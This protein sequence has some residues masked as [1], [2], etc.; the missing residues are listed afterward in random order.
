MEILKGL[1]NVAEIFGEISL[2]VKVGA[3]V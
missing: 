3:K 1:V 2:R